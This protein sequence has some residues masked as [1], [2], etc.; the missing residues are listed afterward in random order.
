MLN[1]PQQSDQAPSPAPSETDS[2]ETTVYEIRLSGHLSHEWADWFDGMNLYL[3]EGGDSVLT[4]VVAD[5]AALHGLLK[6]VR[7]LGMALVSINP[8]GHEEGLP[9]REK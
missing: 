6:K 1:D 9:D 4:G 3:E 8:V 2:R 7:D 5:Q